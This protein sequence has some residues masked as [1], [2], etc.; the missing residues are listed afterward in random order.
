MVLFPFLVLAE[1]PLADEVAFLVDAEVYH[2]E[3]QDY[4]KTLLVLK[5]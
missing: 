2:Q 1:V 3:I 4:Q 5:F